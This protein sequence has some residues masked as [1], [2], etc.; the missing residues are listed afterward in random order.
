VGPSLEFA[1]DLT[2]ASSDAL[3]AMMRTGNQVLFDDVL[4]KLRHLAQ[5]P[6]PLTGQAAIDWDAQTLAEEQN[7]I[8]PLYREADRTEIWDLE[9]ITGSDALDFFPF[10]LFISFGALLTGSKNVTSRSDWNRAGTLPDVE[11]DVENVADRWNYGMKLA[12]QFSTMQ[13]AGTVPDSPPS[14]GPEYQYQSRTRYGALSAN[15]RQDFLVIPPDRLTQLA[16]QL[17]VNDYSQVLYGLGDLLELER[18]LLLLGD[19]L[20]A[21]VS[22]GPTPWA[23]LGYDGVKAFV[24]DASQ[25]ER[26]A[27]KTDGWRETFAELCGTGDVME[28]ALADLN[29]DPTPRI[30]W[31]DA[32]D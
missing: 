22:G 29:V 11:G 10:N 4:P 14:V 31:L 20:D 27:L 17:D 3:Q 28:Q 16:G 8:E 2:H 13:V 23:A 18:Q 30:D 25:A 1:S 32:V 6:S 7:L 9:D 26:N 12:E 15:E 19:T 24:L 21:D 5:L